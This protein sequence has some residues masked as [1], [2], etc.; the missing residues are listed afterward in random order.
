MVGA[1]VLG[2]G[3]P[4]FGGRPVAPLQL[5]EVRRRDDS[6]NVLLRYEVTSTM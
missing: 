5:A 4:A 1:T 2:G 3:T 6:D